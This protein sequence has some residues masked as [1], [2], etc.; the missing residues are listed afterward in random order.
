MSTRVQGQEFQRIKNTLC[1]DSYII[2][3]NGNIRVNMK[4]KLNG[5]KFHHWLNNEEKERFLKSD[6]YK[7]NEPIIGNKEAM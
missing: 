2:S 4:S 1:M 7:C 5:K 6:Y 3:S